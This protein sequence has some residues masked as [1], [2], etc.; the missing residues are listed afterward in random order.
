M[1]RRLEGSIYKFW[2]SG[3]GNHEHKYDKIKFLLEFYYNQNFILIGDSGQK[4]P[5]IYDRLAHDFPGRVE[6][7]YIR[8]IGSRPFFKNIE[9]VNSRLEKVNTS[10]LQ[11]EDTMD[12][13]R[14]ALTN[15]YISKEMIDE[16]SRQKYPDSVI[17]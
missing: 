4:D 3:Q 5:V 11:V 9:Q 6:T 1:L 15:G 14:H 2:R 7:I 12:A 8:K 17:I 10:Y 13:A 16:Y